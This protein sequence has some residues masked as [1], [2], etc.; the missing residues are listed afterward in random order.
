MTTPLNKN[1]KK[2][3]KK[4]D[5]PLAII[6][7][8]EDGMRGALNELV[9]LQL[10]VKATDAAHKEYIV[11]L[12]TVNDDMLA[13]KRERIAMLESGIA[14]FCHSHRAELFPKDDPKSKSY[15]NG[16]VGFRFDPHS[17]STVVPG[18]T[19][20]IIALRMMAAAD[21]VEEKNAEAALEVVPNLE[22]LREFVVMKPTLDKKRLL[23]RRE[24]LTAE[25]HAKLK[26]LGVG[27]VQEEKFYIEPAADAASRLSKPVPAAQESE[28]VA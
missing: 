17:V 18:D 25:Q 28:A 4:S 16:T 22:W 11:S 2:S 27:F 12:N 26:E 13:P 14:L 5:A 6:Y 3:R 21:E 9:E 23:A 19:E 24:Q 20:A 1:K 10:N 8:S 15:E 7:T